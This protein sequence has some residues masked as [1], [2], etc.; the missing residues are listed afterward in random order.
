[1]EGSKRQ[2]RLRFDALSA[3]HEHAYSPR[4]HV[5]QQC[6]LPHTRWPAHDQSATM[7]NRSGGDQGSQPAA[8]YVPAEQRHVVHATTRADPQ[9]LK[10]PSDPRRRSATSYED[11]TERVLASC[12]PLLRWPDGTAQ[13]VPEHIRALTSRTVLA[14]EDDLTTRLIARAE[15]SPPAASQKRASVT[16]LIG[17]QGTDR[18]AGRVTDPAINGGGGA[19]GLDA[20]QQAVASALAGGSSVVVVEGAAGVGKTTTLTAARAAIEEGGRRVVVATP[21]LK[22]AT[23]AA[24][25]T[26]A[27]AYSA[28]WLV[29]QHGYRWDS[30]SNWR[31]L[32]PG[33]TDPYCRT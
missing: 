16:D 27:P 20:A 13:L 29:H 10:F 2:R 23:V 4:S 8:L 30:H 11:L 3:Q 25:E 21:T 24:H 32:Q 28:A 26:G 15:T 9:A 31:R 33:G 14:V 5:L 1:M 12:V 17:G 18:V 19:A 6:R 7:T 22:A